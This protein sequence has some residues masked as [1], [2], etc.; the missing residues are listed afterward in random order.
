MYQWT[1]PVTEEL[2][3]STDCIYSN[4]PFNRFLCNLNQEFFDSYRELIGLFLVFLSILIL[5]FGVISII[6]AVRTRV[7]GKTN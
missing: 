7:I 2:R 5:I 4:G 1:G 6:K 3:S